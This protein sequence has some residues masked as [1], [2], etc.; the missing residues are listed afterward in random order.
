VTLLDVGLLFVALLLISFTLGATVMWSLEARDRRQPPLWL[1]VT[2]NVSQ[3]SLVAYLVISGDPP[4]GIVTIDPF[5]W[6]LLEAF[7]VVTT[8]V[9]FPLE[10]RQRLRR[11]DAT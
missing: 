7:M 11:R 3:I 4:T 10:I 8:L 9:I 1:V 6:S 2:R 5:W